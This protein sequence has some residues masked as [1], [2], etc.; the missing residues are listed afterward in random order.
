MDEMD[1][2]DMMDMMDGVQRCFLGIAVGLLA[3]VFFGSRAGAE[4]WKTDYRFGGCGG[5]YFLAEPGELWVEVEK[6]DLNT[7]GR[8]TH[9]RAILFGPDRRVLDEQWL[10]DDGRKKGS[11]PGPVQ[12]VRLSTQVVHKGVYGLNIT[13]SQDRYGECIAWG[14][15]TNCPRYLI[16]TS[17]GHR[18]APHEEPLV[19]LN[20]ETPGDICFLPRRGEFSVGVTGLPDGVDSLALYNARGEEAGGMAVSEQGE[21]SGSFVN[22]AENGSVPWRLHLPRFRGVVHIDGVT[23][24]RKGEDFENLSLWTPEPGSWFPFHEHRWLLTPYDRIVCAD[25][26]A[27]G[28]IAFQVHNNGLSEKTVALALEFPEE[29]AWSAALSNPEV[30]VPPHA[31]TTVS[32]RYEVPLA[33]DYW[34]CRLRATPRDA[35]EF[36][37]YAAIELRRG[38]APAADPVPIPLVLKP[39]E[40]ENARFGYLPEYPLT[41]Q[42]YFDLRNRPAVT[43]KASVSCYREG[44]WH[45]TASARKPDG[46]TAPFSLRSSKVAFDADNGMYL[47]GLHDGAPALLH[48]RNRGADFDAYAVPGKGGFDIEQFSGHNIPEGPPPFVRYTL[49][50]TDPK[51]FWRRL[52]DLDLFLPE[53]DREG[54]IVIGEPLLLSKKCIGSSMHSGIPSALVSRGTK[55]HVAWAEATEAEE[56]A[57][58]VPTFV[59][60]YDRKTKTL[61]QPALVGYGPPAN[62][63]H[64]TPCIT[65]DSQGH[66]HVLVGTHGR[67]F[68]YARSLEPNDAGKGW[69]EAEDI[70]PGLRQTYV[71]LVCDQEDRL[72]LVFRLWRTDNAYFPASHYACL[73]YMSKDPGGP[74]SEPRPLIVAPFSEYSIFYHRLSIDRRGQLFLSYD[75]WS[76]FWFYR[77]DHRGSRRALLTSPDRG[78]TWKLAGLE[79]MIP[80][81]P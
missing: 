77:T 66:L 14:F 10:P 73:A 24:W 30:I 78:S 25:S 59:V 54:R 57:P 64:N 17:R 12:R 61:T 20:P 21:A 58:G 27:E 67:T 29:N 34:T 42:V 43:A 49:T 28:T 37:T 71:G 6:S 32:V 53:R 69:T 72:H 44:A 33:G 8:K 45:G 52:N 5:V 19:L 3:V 51:V 2:M 60:T 68:R 63:V 13:V 1:M 74:W 35:P 62:D 70:G 50:A 23:R 15:T 31:S 7:R 16:E 76:T 9:L 11:G 39:Y 79:D 56:K 4:E 55:V 46:S 48:S 75:Y 80:V 36:S 41:N 26:G 38:T 81:L 22:A 18:D 47:I 40:H 65:M